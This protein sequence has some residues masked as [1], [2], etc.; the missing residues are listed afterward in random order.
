MVVG[1][2]APHDERDS[3]MN[4]NPT[5]GSTRYGQSV[6]ARLARAIAESSLVVRQATPAD[7]ARRAANPDPNRADGRLAFVN[8]RLVV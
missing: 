5:R 8:G 6:P 7:L 2:T 4:T 1:V 3:T